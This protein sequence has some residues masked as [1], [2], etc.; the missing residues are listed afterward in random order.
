[1]KKAVVLLLLFYI[2]SVNSFS[3]VHYVSFGHINGSVKDVSLFQLNPN[4]NYSSE[5]ELNLLAWTWQGNFGVVRS[6]L[7]FTGLNTIPDNAI[8]LSATL[9][10]YGVNSAGIIPQGNSYYNGSNFPTN[11]GIIGRVTEY[12][13]E[14]TVTWATQPL[15]DTSNALIIPSS[16]LQWNEDYS[17]SSPELVSMVQE[18]VSNNN[19]GFI[20]M[21]KTEAQYRSRVFASSKHENKKLWPVLQV[22]YKY[23]DASFDYCV[24]SSEPN[25]Y[26]FEAVNTNALNYSWILNGSLVSTDPDYQD[27]FESGDTNVLCLNVLDSDS[28]FCEECITIF[29]PEEIEEESIYPFRNGKE[30][31]KI[32]KADEIVIPIIKMSPNPTNGLF[33][34][35]VSNVDADIFKKCVI[36]NPN[37]EVIME[38]SIVL[39]NNTLDL[40]NYNNG[41]YLVEVIIGNEIVFS[42][43]LIKIN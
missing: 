10:L 16:T 27:Y 21:L 30:E 11:Q 12:W 43:K 2:V 41:I 15:F 14:N 38:K 17:V 32:P 26:S 25:V 29:I 7:Q 34:L 6:L 40:T 23:C 36:K 8:I 18:M 1:M 4:N 24:N 19:F 3:Q 9:Y 20:L 35:N 28:L 13:N 31:I 22:S 33:T 5:Q 37:G 39:N 42:D